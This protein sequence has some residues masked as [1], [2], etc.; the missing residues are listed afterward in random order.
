MYPDFFILLLL[1]ESYNGLVFY[2]FSEQYSAGCGLGHGRLF[3]VL[4]Q[5]SQR[6]VD[7]EKTDVPDRWG[8]RRISGTDAADRLDLCS[9][10]GAVFFRF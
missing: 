8:F 2:V 4:G 10:R 1:G 3:G 6:A 7:E 5:R 9:H